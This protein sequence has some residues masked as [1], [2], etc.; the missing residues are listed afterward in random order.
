[1]LFGRV[2]YTQ[3]VLNSMPNVAAVYLNVIKKL[4]ALMPKPEDRGVA[5]GLTRRAPQ[6]TILSINRQHFE[7]EEIC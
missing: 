6:L 7:G 4:I 3:E 1:M 5:M 2:T